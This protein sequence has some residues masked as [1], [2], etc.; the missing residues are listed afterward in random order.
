MIF[1]SLSFIPTIPSLEYL[2]NYDRIIFN[3]VRST[4]KP[5]SSST[6]YGSQRYVSPRK[7]GHQTNRGSNSNSMKRDLSLTSIS[8]NSSASSSSTMSSL[9]SDF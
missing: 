7:T 5:S 4:S 9:Q 1:S 6:R 3:R 8:S 2:L